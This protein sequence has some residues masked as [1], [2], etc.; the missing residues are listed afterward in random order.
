MVQFW[1]PENFWANK[2]SVFII[3]LY[4][5][6]TFSLFHY[7]ERFWC[8][9]NIW[10]GGFMALGYIASASIYTHW[11]MHACKKESNSL[12]LHKRQACLHVDIVVI[13]V[14]LYK[15]ANEHYTHLSRGRGWWKRSRNVA[16][17]SNGCCV[18]YY[19]RLALWMLVSTRESFMDITHCTTFRQAWG[20]RESERVLKKSECWMLGSLG[21]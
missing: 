1:R 5:I 14:L 7:Q 20:R 2:Y 3:T 19:A 9:S 18:V 4:F 11:P 15:P 12:F 6:F 16:W 13:A 17:R 8:L 21:S 10:S